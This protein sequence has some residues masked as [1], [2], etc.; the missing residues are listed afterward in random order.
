MSSMASENASAASLET[1]ELLETS[2]EISG[3]GHASGS[4]LSPEMMQTACNIA[5]KNQT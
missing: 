2:D 5:T 1:E 4:G 3:L